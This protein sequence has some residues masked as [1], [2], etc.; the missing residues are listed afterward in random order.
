MKV[1]FLTKIEKLGVKEAIAF[2]KKITKSID[3]FHDIS[4]DPFPLKAEQENYDL[5]ISYISP[6][7]VPETV[8]I[9]KKR[10]NINFHPGPP[11]YPGIGCFNFAIYDSTKE[12]GATAH[13][14]EPKVDTGKIIGVKRFPITGEETVET[15]SKKTYKVL[16]SLYKDIIDYVVAN[17]SLP[18]SNETWTRKPYKRSE[19][20]DLATIKTSMSKQEIDKRIRATYYPGKPATF[21]E[22]HGYRFEYNPD[23]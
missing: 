23:R 21:M 10:W 9:K 15:L 19:L 11:E 17:D 5:L 14:M 12:F 22:L 6:W 20:E 3:V 16:L 8:L 7:I 18:K 4:V 13:I 2:T 1:C